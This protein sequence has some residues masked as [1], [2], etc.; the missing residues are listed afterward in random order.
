MM[1]DPKRKDFASQ[2]EFQT[3]VAKTLK[4]WNR[5][6]VEF[7]PETI[8]WA[9]AEFGG[10]DYSIFADV[11]QGLI[12]ICTGE[13]TKIELAVLAYKCEGL[14]DV[15]LTFKGTDD[16]VVPFV[17]IPGNSEV[18]FVRVPDNSNSEAAPA[19]EGAAP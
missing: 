1:Q 2:E 12:C 3:A 9:A 13:W 16:E 7:S 8:A 11:T 15:R 19:N 6:T 18:P 14:S 10:G 5:V 17:R 4:K